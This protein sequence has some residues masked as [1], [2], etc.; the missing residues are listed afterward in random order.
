MA[1][2]LSLCDAIQVFEFTIGIKVAVF[3]VFQPEQSRAF[4]QKQSQKLSKISCCDNRFVGD[5]RGCLMV[6][7]GRVK[8][9]VWV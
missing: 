5:W 4:F 7:G 8:V 2:Q 9:D 6:H 1:D 3:K